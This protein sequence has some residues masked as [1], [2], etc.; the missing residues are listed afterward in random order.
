MH[1]HWKHRELVKLV[2]N[3]PDPVQLQESARMLEYESGGILVAIIP[4]SKGQEI[5]MYRGKNYERPSEL[6]PRN[7][8]TKR[9]A[10]KRAIEMQRRAVCDKMKLVFFFLKI[11]KHI[12]TW[13]CLVK[14][15]RVSY[16]TFLSNNIFHKSFVHVLTVI[17]PEYPSSRNR[18][19]SNKG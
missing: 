3:E 4:S 15:K 11:L 14:E 6:R 9:K 19:S 1:F 17:A 7:L 16:P 10:L 13:Y 2:V 5:I 8:L 12:V 18:D